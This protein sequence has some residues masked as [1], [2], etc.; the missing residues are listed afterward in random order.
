MH[1]QILDL[2]ITHETCTV[3]RGM[4]EGINKHVFTISTILVFVFPMAVISILYILIGR[5][6][7]KSAVV[8]R[9]TALGSSVRIKVFSVLLTIFYNRY[10]FVNFPICL[11]SMTNF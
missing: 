7:R 8:Q 10:H 11:F 5:Q 9:G 2:G 1:F 3:K 4:S 6:L